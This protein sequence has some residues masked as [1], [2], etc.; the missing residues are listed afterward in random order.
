MCNTSWAVKPINMITLK[1]GQ[2]WCVY[3][4]RQTDARGKDKPATLPTGFLL[5]LYYDRIIGSVLLRSLQIAS[6]VYRHYGTC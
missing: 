4:T 3:E 2:Q 1:P 6:I 5:T